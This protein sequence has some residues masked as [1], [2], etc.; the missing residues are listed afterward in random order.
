MKL[1]ILTKSHLV[2]NCTTE[3][4]KLSIKDIDFKYIK[5]IEASDIVFFIDGEFVHILKSRF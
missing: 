1:L 3:R 2:P 4:L 5:D